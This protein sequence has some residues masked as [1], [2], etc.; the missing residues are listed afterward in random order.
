MQHI[1]HPNPPN[2]FV[3]YLSIFAF[4]LSAWEM[5]LL[6]PRIFSLTL[7][8]KT[9]TE[10]VKEIDS[11]LHISQ[12]FTLEPIFLIFFFF[13]C[14]RVDQ[15][16]WKIIP[17]DAYWYNLAL[18]RL[19]GPKPQVMISQILKKSFFKPWWVQSKLRQNV[20]QSN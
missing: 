11:C 2:W 20:S 12:T 14:C 13:F 10:E 1:S 9:D 19:V 17:I 16:S 18:K 7:I 6:T 3:L 4:L 8:S 5:M 15:V